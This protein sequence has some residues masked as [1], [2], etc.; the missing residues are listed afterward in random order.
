MRW[1]AVLLA[2]TLLT[3]IG[4]GS[5]TAPTTSSTELSGTGKTANLNFTGTALGGERF[6]GT[7]LAGKPAVRWFWAPWC[8][9]CRAQSVTVSELA[10]KYHGKVAVVG[11][12]GMDSREAIEQVATQIPY[13]K[14]LVDADG[15]IWKHFRVTA[16]SSYEVIS[17]DGE[18]IV[19]GYLDDD[20]LVSVV[21]RLAG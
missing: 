9:T 12:G 16:Q 18:I 14:H 4:C 1:L 10:E 17:A 5:P 6:E 19:E 8:P 20:E 15:A 3:L 2:A 21:D 11:V 13:V 7:S